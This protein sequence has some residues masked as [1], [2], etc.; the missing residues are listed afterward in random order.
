MALNINPK[1]PLVLGVLAIGGL[2]LLTRRATAAST[3]KAQVVAAGSQQYTTPTSVAA[4]LGAFVAAYTKGATPTV[5]TD[6]V[7]NPDWPN[8]SLANWYQPTLDQVS[9]GLGVF[10]WSTSRAPVADSWLKP[11]TSTVSDAFSYG[12][13]GSESIAAPVYTLADDFVMNPQGGLS[14]FGW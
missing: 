4:A 11:S 7:A 12:D 6:K 10:D 14:A 2:W 9:G 8:V 3:P 1:S 5:R 13:A